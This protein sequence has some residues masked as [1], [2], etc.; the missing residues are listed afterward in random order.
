MCFR[1]K[2]AILGTIL[3]FLRL[4]LDIPSKLI[5]FHEIEYPTKYFQC[6]YKTNVLG[7]FRSKLAILGTILAFFRLKFDIPLKITDFD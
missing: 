5:D 3:A 4:K 6:N 1:P 2:L 7:G